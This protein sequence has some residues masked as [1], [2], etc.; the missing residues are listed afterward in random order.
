[1]CRYCYNHP[2]R[3]KH[4]DLLGP[5]DLDAMERTLRELYARKPM[6]ITLHGGEPLYWGVLWGR[7]VVERLLRV[8]YELSGHSGIQTNATLV[9]EE[10]IAMFK[11]FKTSVGAS[12]DGYYPA[13]EFRADEKTTMTAIENIRALVE[14]GVNTGVIIVLHKANA[15]PG[16]IEL[17]EKLILDLHEW[18]VHGGKLNPCVHDDPSIQLTNK[19]L[20][21]A[22]KRLFDFMWEH[23]IPVCGWDP[24]GMM[25]NNLL[26]FHL[27]DCIFQPCDPFATWSGCRIDGKGRVYCCAK[28]AGNPI[29]FD[30]ERTDP[31]LR[32]RILAATDCRGCPYFGKVCFGGCPSTAPGWDWRRKTRFCSA[33]RW[34]YGFLAKKLKSLIPGLTT[35]VDPEWDGDPLSRAKKRRGLNPY[36]RPGAR[37]CVP[38]AA[39]GVHHDG[40]VVHHDHDRHADSP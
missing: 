5:P 30:L 36:V 32:A 37:P 19:E 16:R 7:D 14:S 35:C 40:G 34:L 27:R 29:P 10:Y 3:E 31:E 11:K 6:A 13:N 20:V 25:L 39:P 26:G 23:D 18:G 28:M 38:R 24:F 9:D 15:V 21:W 33:F 12:V 1:M 4:P 2:L 17:V 8:S 22:Y